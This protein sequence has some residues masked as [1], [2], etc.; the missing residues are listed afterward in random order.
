MNDL[1]DVCTRVDENGFAG[2]PTAASDLS[3]AGGS[4]RDSISLVGHQTF[5]F[6]GT[7]IDCYRCR[8][9]ACST[10]PTGRTMIRG[11]WRASV[12]VSGF[13]FADECLHL[14]YLIVLH[15]MT[16]LIS[17]C[18]TPLFTSYSRSQRSSA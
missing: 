8:R 7:T 12:G 14:E 6:Y 4:E 16:T 1:N 13:L 15:T 11:F 10:S 5:Y 2:H 17:W 18:R 3:W 9:F